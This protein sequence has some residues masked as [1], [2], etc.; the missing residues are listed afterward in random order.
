MKG[1][2]GD[3]SSG[4]ELEGERGTGKRRQTEASTD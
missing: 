4:K 1:E 3:D 2:G